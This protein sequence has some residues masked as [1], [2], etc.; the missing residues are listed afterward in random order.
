M[1]SDLVLVSSRSD[2]RDSRQNSHDELGIELDAMSTIGRTLEAIEDPALRQR[3]LNW[4]IQRW[5]S[6]DRAGTDSGE[7]PARRHATTMPAANDSDLSVDSIGELFADSPAGMRPE[8]MLESL[9][10]DLQRLA[11]DWNGA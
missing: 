5:G 1:A 4:A 8:S 2:V 10:V 11:D 9:A 6:A 7:S 3:I